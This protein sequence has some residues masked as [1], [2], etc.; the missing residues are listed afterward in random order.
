MKYLIVSAQEEQGCDYTIGC[1]IDYDVVDCDSDEEA[2]EAAKRDWFD[3][4][5]DGPSARHGYSSD[6]VSVQVARLV[7]NCDVAEWTR[8]T[9]DEISSEK[10]SDE[11]KKELAELERLKSKYNEG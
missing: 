11:E 5:G 8:Q 3:D 2:M 7:G 10:K 1:G 4:D 9:K 6:I